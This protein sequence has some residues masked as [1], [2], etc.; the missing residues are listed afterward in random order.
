[1]L[2]HALAAST[3][4][5]GLVTFY[6]VLACVVAVGTIS[7]GIWR[8]YIWQRNKWTEDG[9]RREQQNQ[10]IEK[11]NEQ[12]DAN[13]RA[14]GDLTRQLIDFV[15]TMKTDVAD[16]RGKVGHVTDRVDGL[17]HRVETLERNANE[18]REP[19]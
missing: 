4:G 6:Y 10:A 7:V 9:K 14:I 12:L 1:V 13:T 16:L 17:H 11:N 3:S 18:I 5:T 15:T 19:R 2:N 8:F